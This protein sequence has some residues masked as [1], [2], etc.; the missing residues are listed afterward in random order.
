M[1]SFAQR[2]ELAH[3]N[4]HKFRHSA[5]TNMLQSNQIDLKSASVMLGHSTPSVTA[6]IYAHALKDNNAK[7]CGVLADVYA[8]EEN[9]NGG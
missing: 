4:P 9:K 6:N 5:A 8:G 2:N 1:Q 3:M 7:A